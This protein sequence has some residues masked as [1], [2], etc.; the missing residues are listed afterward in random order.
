RRGPARPARRARRCAF[1]PAAPRRPPTAP[2]R[3]GALD[4]VE[5]A[6]VL[7]QAVAGTAARQARAPPA[8]AR[9]REAA[10]WP[11]PGK[12]WAAAAAAVTVAAVAA[13]AAQALTASAL[14]VV[15]A[16]ARAA[17]EEAPPASA[18]PAAVPRGC[19]TSRAS[20]EVPLPPRG[21]PEQ[22]PAPR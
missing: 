5:E 19:R 7:S 2:Q 4:V 1:R 3:G 17:W 13:V 20:T 11:Q 8:C 15:V 9:R 16:A 10:D 22:P 18:A 21:P 6:T 14:A 12:A